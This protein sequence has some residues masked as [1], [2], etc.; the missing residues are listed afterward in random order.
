MQPRSSRQIGF[1]TNRSLQRRGTAMVLACYGLGE[2]DSSEEKIYDTDFLC[3]GD[4]GIASRR[5][6]RDF[7][8]GANRAAAGGRCSRPQRRDAGVLASL[9][10]RLAPPLLARPLGS[11]ALLVRMHARRAAMS[12][13]QGGA[14]AFP[15]KTRQSDAAPTTS[16]RRRCFLRRINS[17]E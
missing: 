14:V 16:A 2:Q 3:D 9:A 10:S 13:G 6:F 4:C 8:S 17:R 7:A 1:L 12:A 11:C 15:L 5:C